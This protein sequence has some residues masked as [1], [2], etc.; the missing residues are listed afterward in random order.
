[1]I[2]GFHSE[3]VWTYSFGRVWHLYAHPLGILMK[4]EGAREAKDLKIEK[5]QK[6]RNI[7]I[8]SM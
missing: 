4:G 3:I 5:S 6:Y 2:V 7:V 8:T 1:M